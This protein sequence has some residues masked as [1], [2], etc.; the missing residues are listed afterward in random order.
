M[1]AREKTPY[2]QHVEA[3]EQSGDCNL[4]FGK[5][6]EDEKLCSDIY[7]EERTAVR[8]LIE[9]LQRIKNWVPV[10][11]IPDQKITTSDG[12][13]SQSGQSGQGVPEGEGDS[14]YR[15]KMAF[16]DQRRWVTFA[17]L[18][19]Y[20]S[21]VIGEWSDHLRWVLGAASAM[22]IGIALI[23]GGV[24]AFLSHLPISALLAAMFGVS[25]LLTSLVALVPRAIGLA[26]IAPKAMPAL[27]TRGHL[28]QFFNT[29]PKQVEACTASERVLNQIR[30]PARE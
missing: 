4:L 23:G 26:K 1:K 27:A 8:Q 12:G 17:H 20:S 29:Y 2:Q 18:H 24:F 10:A 21:K 5:D 14:A 13:K 19:E 9:L 28:K 7:E 11:P 22:L 15:L 30:L 25:A 3:M 16:S 6:P